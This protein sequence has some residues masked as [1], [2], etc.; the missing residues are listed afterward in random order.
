[1]NK[2][3]FIEKILQCHNLSVDHINIIYSHDWIDNRFNCFNGL[4]ESDLAIHCSKCK[5]GFGYVLYKHQRLGKIKW[6]ELTCEEV[7]IKKLL[8]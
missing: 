4:K 1:M 8:E 3:E 5:I 2:D 6:H 7:L